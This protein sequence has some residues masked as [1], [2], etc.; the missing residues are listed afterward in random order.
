MAM[1]E[2]ISPTDEAVAAGVFLY[3]HLLLRGLEERGA[4]DAQN[5][6]S[7]ATSDS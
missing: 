1:K 3:F 4:I 6:R 5:G 7:N 2:R